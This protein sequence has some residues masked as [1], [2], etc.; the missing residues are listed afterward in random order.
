MSIA[1]NKEIKNSLKWVLYAKFTSQL[2]SWILTLVSIRYIVSDD[3]GLKALSDVIFSLLFILSS[4]GF[5]SYLVQK[6]ELKLEDREHIF[7]LLL[8]VNFALGISQLLLASAIADYYQDVRIQDIL[9][10]LSFVFFIIPFISIPE[11]LL[12]RELQFK[13][14]SIIV[15]IGN[16]TASVTTLVMAIYGFGVWSLVVGQILSFFIRF[17]LLNR[18]AR[19]LCKPKFHASLSLDVLNFGGAVWLSSLLW[20]LANKVDVFIAGNYF[21]STM[22]GYYALAVYLAALPVEKMMPILQQ[23]AF[24]AYAKLK[25]NKVLAVEYFNKSL[26]MT[27]FLLTPLL[28]GLS[29]TADT[30]VPLV[31]GDH[32]SNSVPFVVVLALI[33]PLRAVGTLFA[34][35]FYAFGAADKQVVNMFF[36]LVM[37]LTGVT[38]GL[39]WG[40]MGV[41]IAW[42]IAY[43]IVLIFIGKNLRN[44]LPVTIRGMVRQIRLPFIAGAI[45]WFGTYFFKQY[46]VTS[47]ATSFILQVVVASAIYSL[48]VW[49]FDRS[50][51]LELLNFVRKSSPDNS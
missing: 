38:I 41:A 12:E 36:Y 4:S 19:W 20:T 17:L 5:S 35:I 43:P 23:V 39:N 31:L 32:W 21:S 22:I 50:Y 11:K 33:Y 26:R 46:L 15:L 28:L 13:R 8:V 30:F 27:S 6:S 40:M 10:A 51:I 25:N 14:L 16:F 3:Y 2:I 34:P 42:L 49:F 1:L 48:I 7:A 37:L 47:E 24:P 44:V 18:S 45:M 9:F 29:V